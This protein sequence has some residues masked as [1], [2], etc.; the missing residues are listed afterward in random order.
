M[1]CQSFG[2]SKLFATSISMLI[3][4]SPFKE[5]LSFDFLSLTNFSLD[6]ENSIAFFVC[7]YASGILILIQY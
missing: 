1:I 2:D 3:G 4:S 7:V 6:A 5:V